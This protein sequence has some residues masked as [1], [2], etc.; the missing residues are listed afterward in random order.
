MNVMLFTRGLVTGLG[1][2]SADAIYGLIAALGLT[3]VSTFLTGQRLWLLLS[4]ITS[5]LRSQIELRMLVRVN[6]IAG[7][8]LVGFGGYLLLELIR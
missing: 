2:A 4:S 8:I 3:A 5:R 7:N 1:A 6:R